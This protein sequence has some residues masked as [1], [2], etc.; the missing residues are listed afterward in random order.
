MSAVIKK[1][2][3]IKLPYSQLFLL[4]LLNDGEVAKYLNHNGFASKTVC[5]DCHVDDFVHVEGCE[6]NKWLVL[7]DSEQT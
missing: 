4:D 6:N 2:E 7:D 5:P 1:E 3:L